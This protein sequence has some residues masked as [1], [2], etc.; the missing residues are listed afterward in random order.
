MKLQDHQNA[1]VI[2][3]RNYLR[4]CVKWA[5]EEENKFAPVPCEV[6]EEAAATL[7]VCC[8]TSDALD[9][10]KEY[11]EEFKMVKEVN[12]LLGMIYTDGWEGNGAAQQAFRDWLSDGWHD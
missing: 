6:A 2:A 8:R 11:E 7:L 4:E 5:A 12:E 10:T 1:L 3:A 9:V